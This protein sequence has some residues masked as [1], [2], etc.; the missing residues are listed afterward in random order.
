MRTVPMEGFRREIRNDDTCSVTSFEDVGGRSRNQIIKDL[1]ARGPGKQTLSDD[2]MPDVLYTVQFCNDNGRVIETRESDQPLD[3]ATLSLDGGEVSRKKPVIEIKSRVSSTPPKHGGGRIHDQIRYSAEDDGYNYDYPDPNGSGSEMD[4]FRVERTEMIIHSAHLLAALAAVV[5]YYPDVDF[6]GEQA[7]VAAP[8]HVLIHHWKELEIYKLN[9]P[10]CHDN[11]YATTTAKHIDVL[12]SFLKHSFA[13]Q[14]EAEWSRWNNTTLPTA[15]FDLFW[16]LLKP[17]EIIYKEKHGQ[18]VPYVISAVSLNGDGVSRP[19]AYILDFWNIGYYHGRLQRQMESLYIYPWSGER[20]IRALQVIPARFIAGGVKA[21]AEKQ[22]KL[23]KQYWEL[24]KQPSYKDYDGELLSRDLTRGGNMTGRVIV[25]CEGWERFHNGP[26][27]MPPPGPPVSRQR[28]PAPP[29]KDYLPQVQPRC[30]CAACKKAGLA[31]EPSTFAGFESL[32]PQVDDPPVNE[33]L[34]FHVIKDTIPAFILEE[35]RW[36]SL[37][38]E[39]LRE[40]KPDKDAFKYLVLDSEVKMTVKALIGKFASSDG[41]VSPWPSDFVKNK[42]EGRI[43][44]LH[45]SPGVG[46]T[47][48]AECV[49]ELTHRPLLSLT[50]GDISTSMSASSV[51]R[52]LNYFLTLGERFGALVLLDEADVYLEE[53]RTRDLRRNGLVSIFLRALEYYRGVLFLTTNRVEAF[54]SAFTSRIHVALHY[55]RL[56]DDDRRR[57][58]MHNFERLERDSGGKCYVPQSAREYAYEGADVRAL[59]WNGREIRNGLQTA[60]A[61]AETEAEENGVETVI[62]TDKHLRSVVKMS[63]GFKEFL[64]R[65]RKVRW[66]SPAVEGGCSDDEDDGVEEEEEEDDEEEEEEEDENVSVS[67]AE[68]E[69]HRHPARANTYPMAHQHQQAYPHPHPHAPSMS[70]HPMNPHSMSPHS[71]SSH[72]VPGHQPYQQ[73]YQQQPYQEPY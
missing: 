4:V 19:G 53:R 45:G 17:G 39:C 26:N 23:G 61:L 9:Q 69:D 41:K 65:K 14:L 57:V 22:V 55:R 35:R 56:T 27:G 7:V 15:T 32:D 70:P 49:A 20:E 16:M 25:D 59:R 6:S 34:Y 1:I 3:I 36:A 46:K 67:S 8:Y 48:T 71:M 21:I 43:F 31:P 52:N 33:E 37:R 5:S 38:I 40:V 58:W 72:P 12:L 66:A 62:V 29:R 51:E 44:L 60:V 50:S 63:S 13:G 24:A 11:E 73:P 2:E 30:I 28:N 10:A 68:T 47:C 18:M 64:N 42:G 54:D